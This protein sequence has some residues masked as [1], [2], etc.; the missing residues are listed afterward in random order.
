MPIQLQDH[1]ENHKHKS[2]LSFSLFVLNRTHKHK[3]KILIANGHA[4]SA[5]GS[6]GEMVQTTELTACYNYLSKKKK[7]ILI[8]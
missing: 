1:G 5:R 8:K 7:K 3:C 4:Q 6:R 2:K